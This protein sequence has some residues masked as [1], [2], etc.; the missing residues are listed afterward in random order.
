MLQTDAVARLVS[1]DEVVRSG[2]LGELKSQA[3]RY[4]NELLRFGG[5]EPISGPDDAQIAQK[6]AIAASLDRA[7]GGGQQSYEALN[8]L[9]VANPNLQNEPEANAKLMATLMLA[10][11]RSVDMAEFARIYR[12]DPSNQYK[13][14]TEAPKAFDEVYR[15]RYLAEEQAL[16]T[17]ILHGYEKPEG[18]PMSP[19]EYLMD[20]SLSSADRNEVIRKT[21]LSYGYTEDQIAPLTSAGGA[22]DMARYFG[23]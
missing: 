11:Q 17:L 12:N 10:Q 1:P 16:K 8:A 18:W 2:A 6:A 15:R 5:Y 9:L 13:L 14:V 19:M 4:A 23:G 20:Q 3:V 22:I 7:S 21:L